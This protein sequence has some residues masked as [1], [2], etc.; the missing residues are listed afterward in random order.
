MQLH[1]Y[2]AADWCMWYASP[3]I[4]IAIVSM[5]RAGM[6]ESTIVARDQTS[7]DVVRKSLGELGPQA[8]APEYQRSSSRALGDHPRSTNQSTK[9]AD[10]VRAGTKKIARRKSKATKNNTRCPRPHPC[11]PLLLLLPALVF[12]SMRANWGTKRRRLDDPRGNDPKPARALSSVH[13]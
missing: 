11:C 2:S 6:Q 13:G 9:T 10:Q 8:G 7:V 1:S 3:A 5:E 12:Q 4:R